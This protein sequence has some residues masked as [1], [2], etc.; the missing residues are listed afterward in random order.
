LADLRK[1]GIRSPARLVDLRYRV[2]GAIRVQ[3]DTSHIGAGV[4]MAAL[5]DHPVVAERLPLVRSALLQSAS[6]QIRTM[7]TN[8]G[9]LLQRTRCSYF[10]D[11]ASLCNKRRQPMETGSHL[12]GLP[13]RR[14]GRRLDRQAVLDHRVAHHWQRPLMRREPGHSLVPPG[15]PWPAL[16]ERGFGAR[17]VGSAA[18]GGPTPPDRPTGFPMRLLRDRGSARASIPCATPDTRLSEMIPPR[19]QGAAA[20][21]LLRPPA[22]WFKGKPLFRGRGPW[23]PGTST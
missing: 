23:R 2:A 15:H 11:T 17:P 19:A 12:G 14:L 21:A 1:F 8:G 7:A 5:A 13:R 6:P 4:T 18:A 10:L 3:G 22:G 16:P 9:N 20:R